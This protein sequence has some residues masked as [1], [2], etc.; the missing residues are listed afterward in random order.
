MKGCTTRFHGIEPGNAC[1]DVWDLLLF[2]HQAP[3]GPAEET[4]GDAGF[5]AQGNTVITIGGIYG[6]IVDVK[7]DNLTQIADNVRSGPCA[8]QSVQSWVKV[9][10]PKTKTPD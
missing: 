5:L 7:D 3:A 1:A 10:Q 9:K 6:Q 8:A 4:Q 2:S